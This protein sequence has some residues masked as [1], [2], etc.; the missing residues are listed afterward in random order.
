MPLTGL[1]SSF[2]AANCY[3][4]VS[5]LTSNGST[6]RTF[7]SMKR[8][9]CCE[10]PAGVSLLD[11]TRDF[12]DRGRSKFIVYSVPHIARQ[13]TNPSG[14]TEVFTSR[15]SAQVNFERASIEDGELLARDLVESVKLNRDFSRPLP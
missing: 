9:A 1:P 13:W 8:T 10:S 6:A 2:I 11:V 12:L 15:L 14:Y 4:N 5:R 7:T 3:S